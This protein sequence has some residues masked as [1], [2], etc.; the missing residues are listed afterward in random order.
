MRCG[1]EPIFV[2][3]DDSVPLQVHDASAARNSGLLHR[4]QLVFVSLRSLRA[5]VSSAFGTDWVWAGNTAGNQE[6]PDRLTARAVADFYLRTHRSETEL[7]SKACGCCTQHFRF[8]ATPAGRIQL[9]QQY[10]TALGAALSDDQ[11]R[12]VLS[13]LDNYTR[14]REVCARLARTPPAHP[15]K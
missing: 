12:F 6:Q 5:R 13:R 14:A 8:L 2:S 1:H 4:A 3:L 10:S 7:V 11:Q 15:P 9:I